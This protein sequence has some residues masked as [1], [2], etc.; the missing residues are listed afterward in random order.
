M[1]RKYQNV[2]MFNAHVALSE[3]HNAISQQEKN[4]YAEGRLELRDASVVLKTAITAA[5]SQKLLNSQTN[6]D[7]RQGINDFQDAKLQAIG[8]GGSFVAT[9]LRVKWMASA[10]ITDPA[11]ILFRPNSFPFDLANAE[12]ILSRGNDPIRTVKIESLLVP[13]DAPQGL[14]TGILELN[15]PIVIS[16][17]FNFGAELVRPNGIQP[18][19]GN[20]FL[21]IEFIGYRLE[22]V[23]SASAR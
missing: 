12:L 14:K 22:P 13:G 21:S 15:V 3:N 16:K 23:S 11:E 6:K 19:A 9:G 5:E 1:K 18:A 10:T 20:Q 8:M 4:E 7:Y 17:D 2:D